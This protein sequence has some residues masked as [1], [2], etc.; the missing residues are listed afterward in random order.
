LSNQLKLLRYSDLDWEKDLEL[1]RSISEYIFK[2]INESVFWSLKRQRTIILFFYKVKYMI[3][4]E[5]I[6]KAVWMQRLLKELKL[7]KF[8]TVIIWINNQK[9]IVLTKNS[10]FYI[11]IKYINICHHFIKEVESHRLIYLNYILMNNI[12]INRLTKSLLTLKFTY[13]INLMSLISQ[14]KI[15]WFNDMT[16]E[17]KT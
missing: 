6:K 14:W 13:F 2:I 16:L 4:T 15:L 10:E 7:K 1:R 12:I 3:L 8:R 5:T 9:T 11:Y 17:F